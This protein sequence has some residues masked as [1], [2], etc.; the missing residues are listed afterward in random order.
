MTYATRRPQDA[1]SASAYAAVGLETQVMSAS[2][3]RLVTLMFGGARAAIAQARI[4]LQH[5]RTAERGIAISKAIRIVSE[6]LRQSLDMKAGGEIA[7]TLDDLYD[8][9]LRS[10][11]EANLR[12]DVKALDIADRL[13]ADLEQTW[14]TSVDHQPQ[15]A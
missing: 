5:G 2:P 12:A 1:R 9:I 7:A 8:Y 3:V 15:Q 10:L 11:L 6:G 14:T 4:H 13:L